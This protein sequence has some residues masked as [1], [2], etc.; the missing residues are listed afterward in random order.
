MNK[1]TKTQ[2][3]QV[4][5][6]LYVYFVGHLLGRVS[7]GDVWFVSSHI[8]PWKA[9]GYF[10]EAPSWERL[11]SLRKPLS[12]RLGSDHFS[13]VQRTLDRCIGVSSLAIKRCS[14]NAYQ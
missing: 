2:D 8:T 1:Q 13:G 9:K 5:E 4:Y 7:P 14:P 3:Q 12:A 10:H 6:G 11:V